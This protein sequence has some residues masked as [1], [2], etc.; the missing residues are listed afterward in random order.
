ML[1]ARA[2]ALALAL[3][4]SSQALDARHGA[5]DRASSAALT[6][7]AD[8][9][10][11]YSA[12]LFQLD[13]SVLAYATWAQ[14]LFWPGDPFYDAPP[15][16]GVAKE[17]RKQRGI[18]NAVRSWWQANDGKKNCAATCKQYRAVRPGGLC[19]AR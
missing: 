13:L 6:D 18:A 8:A 16:A 9:E 1:R 3:A 4:A 7:A 17:K 19:L 11:P 14:S 5:D 15:P 12:F 2:I 10:L